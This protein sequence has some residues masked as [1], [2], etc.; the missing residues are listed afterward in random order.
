MRASITRATSASRYRARHRPVASLVVST[1]TSSYSA[2]SGGSGLCVGE[3][4]GV[5]HD[6]LDLLVELVEVVVGQLALLPAC[7]CAAA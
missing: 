7:A 2:S 1:S 5:L 4:P 3:V 6:R